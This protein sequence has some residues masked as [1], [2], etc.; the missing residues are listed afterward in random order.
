MNS[1]QSAR[2]KWI[3][4]AGPVTLLTAAGAAGLWL[5]QTHGEYAPLGWAVGLLALPVALGVVLLSRV[6]AARRFSA[7]LEA[8]AEQE[9]ARAERRPVTLSSKS[10]RRFSRSPS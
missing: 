8:Y 10:K 6:R 2:P 4:W 5:W 3:Y 1:N 9:L 7:A